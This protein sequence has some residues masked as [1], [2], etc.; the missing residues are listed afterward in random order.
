MLGV[1][2]MSLG[3][4]QHI[5][6]QIQ[7]LRDLPASSACTA[8]RE[9]LDIFWFGLEATEEKHIQERFR[10]AQISSS[11]PEGTGFF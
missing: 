1:S 2:F 7:K 5:F 6:L 8:N 3:S 11:S 4:M 9:S 10:S